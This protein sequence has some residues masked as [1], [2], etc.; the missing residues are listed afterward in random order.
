MENLFV[1]FIDAPPRT[2]NKVI[3]A[4]ITWF[5]QFFHASELSYTCF[6]PPCHGNGFKYIFKSASAKNKRYK[7]S[8]QDKLKYSIQDISD[9]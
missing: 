6:N 4:C 9:S 7:Y 8:I 1:M 2:T 3:L 5:R